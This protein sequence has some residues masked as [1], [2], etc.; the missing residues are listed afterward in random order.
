MKIEEEAKYK[1]DKVE[2]LFVNLFW[3]FVCFIAIGFF[4]MGFTQVFTFENETNRLL[5]III[6][7]MATVRIFTWN[8]HPTLHFK[9]R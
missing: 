4:T 7:A 8:G 3:I 2:T 9:E 5:G 1:L 6:I